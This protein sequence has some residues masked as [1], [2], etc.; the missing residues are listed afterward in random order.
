VEPA[1]GREVHHAVDVAEV[2]LVRPRRV[3]AVERPVAVGVG[4]VQPVELR[5][6]HR[7]HHREALA[8]PVSR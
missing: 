6:H 8:P 1:R 3:V 2:G 5:E 7:L 4:R